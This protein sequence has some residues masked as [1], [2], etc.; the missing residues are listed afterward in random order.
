[1]TK[2]EASQLVAAWDEYL[3]AKGGLHLACD[4]PEDKRVVR[5]RE[6]RERLVQLLSDAIHDYS[7]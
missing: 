5:H 7:W 2:A 3:D 4:G 6:C 1:L